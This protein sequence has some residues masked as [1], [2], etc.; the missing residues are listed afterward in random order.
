VIH[1]DSACNDIQPRIRGSRITR[2]QFG[3]RGIRHQYR[4]QP[5]LFEMRVLQYCRISSVAVHDGCTIV[6]KLPGDFRVV[7]DYQIPDAARAGT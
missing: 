2:G 5:S 6:S 7:F 1:A 3:G 4:Q